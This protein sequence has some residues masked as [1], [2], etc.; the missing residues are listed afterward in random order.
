MA[1]E[2]D[3]TEAARGRAAAPF[4]LRLP[5]GALVLGCVLTAALLGAA[6]TA[7]SPGPSIVSI[8]SALAR[9]FTQAGTVAPIGVTQPSFFGYLEFDWNPNAPGGVPGFG[10]Q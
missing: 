9:E 8:N 3:H 7:L 4:V 5:P 10:P 6:A 1:E 2:S